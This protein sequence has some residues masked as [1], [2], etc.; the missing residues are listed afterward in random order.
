MTPLLQQF[1]KNTEQKGWK[2]QLIQSPLEPLAFLQER[3]G[4]LPENL[5]SFL[6]NVA[7]CSDPEGSFWFLCPTDYL[8][9]DEEIMSW[10]HF[11][12][13]SLDATDDDKQWANDIK[14]FWDRH[15]PIMISVNSGYAYL[16]IRYEDNKPREVVLGH[17]PEFEEVEIIA[18]N[19]D[20]FLA[21]FYEKIVGN[22][23]YQYLY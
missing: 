20:D 18:E 9:Q 5:I 12:E 17:E 19:Y 14:E 7:G 1:I 13:I 6:T 10:N 4:S 23:E 3:Y 21:K 11:E 8:N 22:E 16:A 2:R 15:L